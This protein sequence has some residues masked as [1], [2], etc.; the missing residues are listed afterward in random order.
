MDETEPQ[1][2]WRRELR[3][4]GE[5]GAVFNEAS[6]PEIEVRLP[7][8]LAEQAVAAWE[9][10]DGEAPLA[11]ESYEQSVQRR[12][13]ATLALIGLAI[14]NAGRWDGD[15]VVVELHPVFIG[16]AMDAADDLPAN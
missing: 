3:V 13:A 11:P 10:D 5:A 7:R 14:T 9:R 16:V 2:T 1:K 12:R 4:L 6:L 15:E 8:H